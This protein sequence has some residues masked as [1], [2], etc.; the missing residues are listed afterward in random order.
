MPLR[1]FHS[2]FPVE[3]LRQSRHNQRKFHKI[4]TPVTTTAGL[5][6]YAAAEKQQVV[7]MATDIESL[8]PQYDA[9]RYARKS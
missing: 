2:I 7:P 3:L 8:F 4:F 9:L 5:E 6:K 1:G